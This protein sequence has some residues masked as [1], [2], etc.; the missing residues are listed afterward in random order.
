MSSRVLHNAGKRVWITDAPGP[1]SVAIVIAVSFAVMVPALLWGI[2]SNLDLTNHFRF[3]IPF[4][5]AVIAGDFYPSWLAES[6][7]GYGDPSFRF[8][9]PGFYYLLAAF[10]FLTG[11]WYDA[12]LITYVAVSILSGLG[13]YVWA[14]AFLPSRTAYWAAIFY[15]LAPYH[16]NQVYQ[17]VMLADWAGSA[18]LPFV[19][20][21]VDRVCKRGSR[22]DIAGLAFT[23]GLL[24]FTHLPLAVIGSIALLVYALVRLEATRKLQQLAKLSLAAVMGLALSAIYWV[25][26]ISE[27]GWIAADKAD[28]G[29]NVNYSYSFLFWHFTP[30][31]L[32]VWWFNIL[33]L[34]TFLLCAPAILLFLRRSSEVRNKIRP[35]I[36]IT[37]FALFMTLPLSW[38]IWIVL[39][40]L[41]ETQFPWRWLAV[42]SMGASVVAATALPLIF[43]ATKKLAR[44]KLI[45]IFGAMAISLAFTFS[46][47][48]R[49]AQ[50][51]SATKFEEMTTN[52]RGSQSISYWIPT[53]ARPNP[54]K[55]NE[56]EAGERAVTVTSWE[57]E[58]RRFSVAAGPAVE[59]RVRT[60]AYP[61]WTARNETGVLPTRVDQDGA[62]LISLPENATSVELDFTEPRKTKISTISSLSALI[63]LATLFVPFRRKQN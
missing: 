59:A 63:I 20:G 7:G 44:P 3:A 58:H 43:D 46:H 8:Y 12:T 40:P 29:G 51:F 24:I 38:P 6:N 35:V 48:I 32:S 28:G 39:K 13:T 49:E 31:N 19:F 26:M 21:F 5:E 17:A 55:M 2:P 22:K 9:P 4:G 14:R 57:P 42:F 1:R 62:L 36:F 10:R 60:F 16:V 41:Q 18:V 34:M 33:T 15:A 50:Y 30:D 54:R 27:V 53:W 45:L 56:V 37:A 52:V 25:T 61:H 11:S 47:S 23:Y